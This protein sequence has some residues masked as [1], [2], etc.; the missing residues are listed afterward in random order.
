M[1]PPTIDEVQAYII[2][3]NVNLDAD[4]FF[5][6]YEQKGWM[7]GKHPMKSWH[8][9]VGL[10]SAQGWGKTGKSDYYHHKRNTKLD[11]RQ[12]QR[13]EYEDHFRGKTWA[14]LKDLRKDP[15]ALKHVAWLMDEILEISYDSKR[16]SK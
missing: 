9:A 5:H 4:V 2:E 11:H 16:S 12:K 1:T 14:A 7:V 13:A 3:K 6:S 15:G 10:W 8:S